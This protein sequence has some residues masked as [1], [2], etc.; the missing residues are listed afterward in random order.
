MLNRRKFNEWKSC[1]VELFIVSVSFGII[2]LS[3]AAYQVL[4]FLNLVRK[5]VM[6]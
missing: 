3:F 6:R 5:L 4:S 1:V 2:A